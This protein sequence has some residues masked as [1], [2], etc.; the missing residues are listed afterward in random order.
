MP[1]ASS[2]QG[3]LSHRRIH[4]RAVNRWKAN[5]Q[6]VAA[7]V[8]ALVRTHRRSVVAVGGDI[9]AVGFFEE[10]L[11]GDVRPLLRRL[12]AGA[13]GPESGPDGVAEEVLRMVRTVETEET[14]AVLEEFRAQH[15]QEGRGAAGRS[16]VFR[17]LQMASVD[18]LLVPEQT[19]NVSAWFGP[20][21]T[22]VALEDGELAVMGVEHPEHAELGDVAVWAALS[23][24]ANVRIVP[25]NAL[26]DGIAA[27]LRFA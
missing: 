20:E 23:T 4:E 9:A 7:E 25:G 21:P 22:Q 8:T 13:R 14:V 24:G 3:G 27:I 5:S 11:P 2:Y 1:P 19:E 18:T 26:P 6:E 15:A 12:E 16:A 10:A 17:A